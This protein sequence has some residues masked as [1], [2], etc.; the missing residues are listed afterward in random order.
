MKRTALERLESRSTADSLQERR[1][2]PSVSS[3]TASRTKQKA[4]SQGKSDDYNSL[5][6][7]PAVSFVGQRTRPP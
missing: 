7:G 4:T 5:E 3:K 1:K 2:S 6:K